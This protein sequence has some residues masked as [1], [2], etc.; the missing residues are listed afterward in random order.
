[1]SEK[2]INSSPESERSQVFAVIAKV[3]RFILWCL[4]PWGLNQ[5]WY[6]EK[7]AKDLDDGDVQTLFGPKKK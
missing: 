4:T 2:T 6:P 7:Y 5:L 1:M 3:L